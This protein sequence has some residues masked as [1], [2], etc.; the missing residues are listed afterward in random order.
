MV[1]QSSDSN[2]IGSVAIGKLEP[3]V[4]DELQLCLAECFH[5]PTSV[6]VATPK[7]AAHG[8]V[9]PRLY[10]HGA[11]L[12]ADT[13]PVELAVLAEANAAGLLLRFVRRIDLT[14][15]RSPS[16]GN[17][18]QVLS[19]PAAARLVG[20]ALRGNGALE[21][22]KASRQDFG[23]EGAEVIGNALTQ[24]CR[25]LRL[26]L[27]ESY[28]TEAGTIPLAQA[29]IDQGTRLKHLELAGNALG[30]SGCRRLAEMIRQNRALVYLG[31]QKNKI[32]AAGA[33]ALGEA[34]PSNCTLEEL[35]LGRNSV[36]TA[37]ARVLAAATRSNSVLRKLNLQDN[38]LDVIA[39]TKIAEE[40]S[41]GGNR[42]PY[43]PG[44]VSTFR[45]TSEFKRQSSG[46]RSTAH[47]ITAGTHLCS[48]NLRHNPIGSLGASA[49]VSAIQGVSTKIS[50]L[51]LAWCELG[52]ESALA[53]A[54]MLGSHSLS[55]VTKLDLRDNKGLG[56]AGGLPRALN[57]LVPSEGS[58]PNPN[59]G[60]ASQFSKR[61]SEAKKS[62][63]GEEFGIYSMEGKNGAD[64]AG[65]IQWLN[66]ANIDLDGEGAGLLAPSM[67]AFRSLQELFLYNNVMLG[68]SA[69]ARAAEALKE[70]EKENEE[71]WQ[72]GVSAAEKQRLELA[73][74]VHPGLPALVEALPSKLKKL[75]LG[76]CALGPVVVQRVLKTLASK[77]ALE[78]LSLSDNDLGM[79]LADGSNGV[80][81]SVGET[82]RKALCNFIQT[83][84]A[85]R[86]FDLALNQLA[87]QCA[88][89][90]VI[91]LCSDA[92]KVEVD[93]GANQVTVGFKRVIQGVRN[94]TS[95]AS[96]SSA[97]P[98][99]EGL[100][101]KSKV[102]TELQDMLVGAHH[103]L[104]QRMR[105]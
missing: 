37:G 16:H 71:T 66:L 91:C 90:I 80:H 84:P 25:L 32:A 2:H 56:L 48:L 79:G 21:E 77:V 20:S 63:G 57:K 18:H 14:Q 75:S 100:A 15:G 12:P 68:Y 39:A 10:F 104:G 26:E 8:H 1:L 61:R 44:S 102:V 62:D 5:G 42:E 30:C 70:K 11:Q 17:Q 50:E 52:L 59:A 47:D 65:H 41:A 95:Q 88:L 6:D 87:D 103:A 53:I 19:G 98:T 58:V 94:E 3:N 45:R 101:Q 82:M 55:K 83:A 105:F 51:N 34:L 27:A 72:E 74:P 69:A 89:D 7:A 73:R 31:L 4:P 76:S 22:L 40:I 9:L 36:E 49:L 35:D 60:R 54:Y 99:V 97:R 13:C 64:A 38:E 81:G 46:R 92:P 96:A 23:D 93:F 29:L 24:D 86:R 33:I 43:D 85:L 78:D 67:S 28:I